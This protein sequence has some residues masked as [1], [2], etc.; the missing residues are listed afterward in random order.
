MGGE[1]F[2]ILSGEH[3]GKWHLTGWMHHAIKTE[4]VGRNATGWLSIG[5]C[6]R[7]HATV[8]TEDNVWDNAYHDQQWAHEDWHAA[9]D[10]PHPVEVAAGDA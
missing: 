9:T 8:I 2:R 1:W 5:I 10:Y 4:P 7:C 6:P 3:E